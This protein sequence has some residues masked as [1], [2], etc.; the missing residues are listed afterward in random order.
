MYYPVLPSLLICFDV[1]SLSMSGVSLQGVENEREGE[2]REVR[3]GRGGEREE[4]GPSEIGRVWPISAST[5]PENIYGGLPRAPGGP[6]GSPRA[7]P[8]GSTP[9]KPDGLPSPLS[10]LSIV[11]TN[12]HTGPPPI[13]YDTVAV[14]ITEE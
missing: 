3:S 12:F 5:S 11:V 7:S 1:K 9:L 8:R 4:A 14:I 6:T 13:E 10:P 2:G